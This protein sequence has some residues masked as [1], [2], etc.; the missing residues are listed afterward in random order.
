MHV[1]LRTGCGAVTAVEC[2]DWKLG[3]GWRFAREP[4]ARVDVDS[5]VGLDGGAVGDQLQR[6]HDDEERHD[7][8]QG[9]C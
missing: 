9:D 3:Q 4:R 5:M 7:E 8:C 1:R 2:H 6:W